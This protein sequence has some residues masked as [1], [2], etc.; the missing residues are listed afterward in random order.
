MHPIEMHHYVSLTPDG[1]YHVQNMAGAL[2][3]QH[4]VHSQRGFGKWKRNI[5][6]K[7]IHIDKAD[8]CECGLE[9]GYVREYDG[10][11]WFNESLK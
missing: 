1:M 11:V 9:P 7:Y 6:K 4:H 3:G 5:S 2:V 8:S 10:R